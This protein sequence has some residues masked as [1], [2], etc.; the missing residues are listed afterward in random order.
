M[1]TFIKRQ[2]NIFFHL[3][4]ENYEGVEEQPNL[5]RSNGNYINNNGLLD[6]ELNLGQTKVTD[7]PFQYTVK[8][9]QPYANITNYIRKSDELGEIKQANYV[10]N[11]QRNEMSDALSELRKETTNGLKSLFTTAVEKQRNFIDNIEN[12]G[13]PNAILPRTNQM[14]PE[15][16]PSTLQNPTRNYAGTT[17]EM[18]GTPIGKID[19]SITSQSIGPPI[20]KIV[21]SSTLQPAFS[22]TTNIDDSV[23]PQPTAMQFTGPS[24]VQGRVKYN[25]AI[26]IGRNGRAAE[27]TVPYDM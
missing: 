2:K 13:Q 22:P 16:S 11:F 9:A 15:K 5:K 7:G 26:D 21:D 10:N 25:I 27:P 17:P 8:T 23:I 18:L 12:G 3:G 20:G 14:Y 24:Q 1:S 6:N 4:V 19:D